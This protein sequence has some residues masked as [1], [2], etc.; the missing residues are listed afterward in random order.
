[1]VN[2]ESSDLDAA[3]ITYMCLVVLVG[4]TTPLTT[5]PRSVLWQRGLDMSGV[6]SA[7]KLPV[8]MQHVIKAVTD[9]VVVPHVNYRTSFYLVRA[10]LSR[11]ST[12]SRV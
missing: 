1:M 2:F 10:L 4:A 7:D 9:E 12:A 3:R 5:E 6:E 8:Y 11:S